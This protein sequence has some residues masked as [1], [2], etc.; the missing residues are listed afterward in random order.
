MKKFMSMVLA[1]VLVT[2][3]MPTGVLAEKKD[4]LTVDG[5]QTISEDSTYGALK[6]TSG[7]LTIEEGKTLTIDGEGDEA[8]VGTG[9][10][11]YV[12]G[13]KIV[14]K[15]GAS[16][17]ITN[18][19]EEMYAALRTE[20]AIIEVNGG[21]LDI[22]NNKTRGMDTTIGLVM[23]ITDGGKL[24]VNNNTLNAMNGVG[25]NG[26]ITVTDSYVESK[27]NLLGGLNGKFILNGK[28][29]M[30]ATGNGLSGVVF[31]DG[32]VISGTSVVTIEDNN[33]TE[34]TEKADLLLT[35]T[36]S[37][38]DDANLF[39]STIGP[40][41]N[42]WGSYDVV[43]NTNVLVDG[44]SAVVAVGVVVAFCDGE[45]TTNESC[46]AENQVTNEF[47]IANGVILGYD[48]DKDEMVA[49]IGGTIDE[50]LEI[51]AEVARVVLLDNVTEGLTIKAEAGTVIENNSANS[52]VVLLGD[53]EIT[54]ESG[55]EVTIEATEPT[56]E[57]KPDE[58]ENPN[59]GDM[60][61]YMLISLIAMAFVAIIFAVKKLQLKVNY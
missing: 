46:A 6:M 30:V 7:T 33:T 58:T 23:T 15:K 10:M 59:T 28:S 41:K 35:G 31:A 38:N 17:V 24:I 47:N 56:P 51:P 49:T 54:V 42:T 11:V 2:I 1:F 43:K 37:V 3:V 19:T 61:L 34:N 32:S 29:E 8:N 53:E 55:K 12:T 39:A 4:T 50:G 40:V 14:V 21:I 57:E 18:A 36:L 13:G 25:A 16:L 48:F 26:S 45:A 9:K 52:V 22:S 27:D 60:N 20:N 5:D 44:S